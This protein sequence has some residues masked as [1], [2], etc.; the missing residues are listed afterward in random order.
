MQSENNPPRRQAS[1]GFD[2]P[3]IM[4][5][6]LALGRGLGGIGL[7]GSV[8]FGGWWQLTR[9]ARALEFPG[10]SFDVAFSRF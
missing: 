7:A 8:S 2:A 5:T 6:L 4:K 9:D 3:G 10:A 1:Y